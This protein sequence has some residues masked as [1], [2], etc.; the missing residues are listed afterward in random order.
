MRVAG[1]AMIGPGLWGATDV[2]ILLT[3]DDGVFAPGLRALRKELQRLG[4]VTVIAPAQE[5]SGVGH[6]IT[7]LHPLVVKPVDD[8]EGAVL[9]YSV[10][11]SPADCVKLAVL[12]LLDRPPDLIVSGINAGSNAGINVLYSGT[13][14][15]AIEGAFFKITSVAV[16]LELAEHFDYPHAAKNAVRVIEKI[17]A[18]SPEQG[19]LFNINLPAHS[20]GE[21]KGVRVVPM[22]VGRYGE[23]FERRKDPRG[24]TYYWMTYAPPYHLDGPETDVTSLTEGYITVTPLHFDMTKY[25]MLDGVGGWDWK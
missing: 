25:D 4:D 22:G 16:S 10:E 17:L 12:E 19:S 8:E 7:L 1:R 20:R 15:A 3:N 6:S 13:V 18:N 2:R 24:R 14:A 21:P 5:Q 11:G 9:G 23:G